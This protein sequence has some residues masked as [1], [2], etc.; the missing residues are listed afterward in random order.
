M[1]TLLGKKVAIEGDVF[2]DTIIVKS[3]MEVPE[4]PSHGQ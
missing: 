4:S 2:R 1:E 3:L